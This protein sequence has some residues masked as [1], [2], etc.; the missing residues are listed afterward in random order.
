[1]GEQRP[2]DCQPPSR[3][4]SRVRTLAVPF[5]VTLGVSAGLVGCSDDEGTDTV[6]IGST[7]TTEASTGAS[8]GGTSGTDPEVVSNP[9]PPTTVAGEERVPDPEPIVNPPA[10]STTG[11]SRVPDAEQVDPEPIANP[12]AP[13]PAPPTTAEE[14]MADPEPIANPPV[15]E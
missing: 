1:M 11:T 3:R 5:V 4:R 7:A 12:P 8:T 10:P 15:P 9:P 13:E 6:D 2:Q 14:K